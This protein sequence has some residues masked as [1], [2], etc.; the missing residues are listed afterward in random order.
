MRL[1][2]NNVSERDGV[3]LVIIGAGPA[4]LTA[5]YEALR[6]DSAL[7]PLVIEASDQV[8]GIARTVT[9]NGN[10]FDIGGH[11]FFTK[12]PKSRR[13]GAKSWATISSR[14]IG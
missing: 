8:G 4:G 13:C 9:H 3:P 2:G 5:A 6:L 7:K 11:R 14:L 10:R 1:A 12:V